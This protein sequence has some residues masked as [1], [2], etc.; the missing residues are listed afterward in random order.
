MKKILF[1]EQFSKISG[2][3]IVLLQI[4][5]SLDK[6][7]YKPYVVIPDKGPLVDKLEKLGIKYFVLPIGSYSTGNKS[8]WDVIKYI[9]LSFIMVFRVFN[10][11]AKEKID[12]VYANAP[13]TYVW[14][15]IAAWLA[16]KPIIWHLHSI[17]SGWELSVTTKIIRVFKV[18]KIIA[19][20]KAVAQP[21]LHQGISVNIIYN[22][23]ACELYK[24]NAVDPGL[25]KRE[26][27]ITDGAKIVA[28]IGQLAKWKGVADFIKAA[29]SVLMKQANTIYLV[30]GDV[31]YGGQREQ[32]FKKYLIDLTARLGI[33]Q[34]VYFLGSRK[35]VPRLLS[36]IDILIVPS[37]EPEPL[38]LALLEGMAS[39]KA[40]VAAAHGG[41]VEII[42]N[43]LNGKLYPPKDINALAACLEELLNNDDLRRKI[44][45]NARQKVEKELSLEVFLQQINSIIAKEVV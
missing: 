6:N 27:G 17:I 45:Q 1:L 20:S 42:N 7:K 28:Y 4:L 31:V 14:G 11:I 30:I 9:T 37:I 13:R 41:P 16:R 44:G 38:S 23:V 26:L 33:D 15:T 25:I 39:G 43:G 22:G 18:N 12:L 24:F 10:I 35:D 40:V 19:I 36:A 29:K 3:Q 34:K 21:Y 8:F 2:G 32:D 5:S